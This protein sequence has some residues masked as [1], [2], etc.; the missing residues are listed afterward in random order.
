MNKR[1]VATGLA[2]VFGLTLVGGVFLAIAGG[3][4]KTTK[5]EGPK[6]TTT[7]TAP[8][9]ATARRLVDRLAA[10]RKRTLHL[11]YSGNLVSQ[12]EAGKLTIEV[13]WKGALAKQSIRAESPQLN[14]QQESYVL[15][16]GNVSC[17]KADTAAWACQRTASV[18]TAS[19]RPGGIIDSLVSSLNGKAVTVASASVGGADVD[20]YTLDATTGDLLC[21]RQDGVPVKFTLS[22]SELLVSTVDTTVDDSVFTPPAEPATPATTATTPTTTG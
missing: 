1:V 22:G 5:V 7:T 18:A 9:T 20:C 12:P 21:L 16:A 3:G 19:G 15:P 17:A 13:W 4:S 6:A 11:V 14:Q 10:A 2:V 8:L